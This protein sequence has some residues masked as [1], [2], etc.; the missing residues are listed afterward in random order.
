MKEQ[1]TIS[2]DNK[3]SAIIIPGWVIL[4]MRLFLGASFLAAGLD[5]LGDPA[6]L[7]P[8]AREYIG[9]QIS[10]FAPGT[11]LEVFLLN[12]ALPNAGLFG[13]MVMG[14][15][16]CIGVAALLG[17]L[18]RGSAAMGLLDQPDIL[19]LRNMGYAPILF[20]RRSS[21]CVRLANAPA[22][23]SRAVRAGPHSQ[24]MAGNSPRHCPRPNS[25]SWIILGKPAHA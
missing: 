3:P 23:G 15:E 18:T 2:Q 8:A 20:W 6:F 13:V 21:L 17:L 5:K 9:Q 19:P 1:H 11:P 25:I 7:D 10:G 22:C 24:E 14:G 4:P 16:L 12:V